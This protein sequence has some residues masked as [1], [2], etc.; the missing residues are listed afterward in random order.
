LACIPLGTFCRQA[1]GQRGAIWCNM[2]DPLLPF[3]FCHNNDQDPESQHGISG[4]VARTAVIENSLLR[5]SLFAVTS[6]ELL[7]RRYSSYGFWSNPRVC[8]WFNT[9]VGNLG[10]GIF[11]RVV[12]A[13]V[14]EALTNVLP[15]KEAVPERQKGNMQSN[16]VLNYLL[17]TASTHKRFLGRAFMCSRSPYQCTSM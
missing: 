9:K 15:C 17:V 16:G 14:L 1:E 10:R 2:H 8:L 7:A 12:H 6:E 3:I 11:F 5:N 4:M 13:C